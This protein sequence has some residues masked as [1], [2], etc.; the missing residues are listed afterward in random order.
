MAKP[1][2]FRVVLESVS[3][4]SSIFQ[5]DDIIAE[6]SQSLTVG[7]V[8]QIGRWACKGDERIGDGT[9][10]F[11][12]GDLVYVQPYVGRMVRKKDG[13]VERVVNDNEIWGAVEADDD[14][15]SMVGNYE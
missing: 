12:V 5:S 2:G 1:F 3:K 11:K 6:Q 15:E 14:I 9:L 13:S 8:K 7:K 4:N 10:E